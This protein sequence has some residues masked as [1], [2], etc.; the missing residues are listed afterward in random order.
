MNLG[1]IAFWADERDRWPLW[2]PVA[3]GAGAGGYFALPVEP[4]ITMG[5]AALA[6]A[7]LAITIAFARRAR[8]AMAL[9]AAVLLGF[10]LAKLREAA[11]ATPV[12]DHAI[13]AH[14]TARIVSIEPRERDARLVMDEVR[15]GAFAP[16]QTPRRIR[17]T[18]PNGADFHPGA[19]LSLTARLDTPSVP[20][21]PGTSDFGRW[22]YFQSIGATG[23]SYGRARTIPPARDATLS[24]R[25]SQSV[26]GLRVRMTDRIHAGLPG[27]AGGIA[28]SLITGTRGT[29]SDEDDAAL[30]YAGLAHAL[31]ISG[32]HIA[33]VGGG[34]FWLVRALLAAIPAV[35]LRYPV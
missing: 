28:A 1:L 4:S 35:A 9:L 25:M 33:L 5:W 24:E 3:L 15:S 6:A 19:W 14:L 17:V 10:G 2:L 23:F 32:L 31:S 34:I 22:L 11:I 16:G 20:V 27:S 8:V 13:V 18:L 30:R 29:I 21:A 26:E 12:L 7:L